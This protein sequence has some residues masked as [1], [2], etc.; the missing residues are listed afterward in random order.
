M[1]DVTLTYPRGFQRKATDEDGQIA[2][3]LQVP[4]DQELET[5]Y[6]LCV[7]RQANTDG[8]TYRERVLQTALRL[9]GDFGEW[10]LLQHRNPQLYGLNYDFLVDT[11]QYIRTG[12]RNCAPLA[13]IEVVDEYPPAK[14]GA[15][16]MQNYA[17][18]QE[19]LGVVSTRTANVLAAWCSRP[20]GFEDLLFSLHVMFGIGIVAPRPWEHPPT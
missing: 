15:R 12:Q 8:W 13:W 16:R 20:G 1:P 3:S 14:P 6:R 5:L 9:F 18:P 7:Y 19:L 4:G 2:R 10:M 11:Y 17:N